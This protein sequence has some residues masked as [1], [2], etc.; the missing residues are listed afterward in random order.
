MQSQNTT[1]SYSTQ[2]GIVFKKWKTS[3]GEPMAKLEPLCMASENKQ[4]GASSGKSTQ[5]FHTTQ[6]FP[7]CVN[8]EKTWKQGLAQIFVPEI[9]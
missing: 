3:A 8:T 2:T 6:Q 9:S 7:F 1:K 5:K 4:E